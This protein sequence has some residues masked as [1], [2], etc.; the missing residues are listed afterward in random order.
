MISQGITYTFKSDILQSGE[1]YM[2]ALYK[3]TAKLGPDV[4]EAYTPEGECKGKGYY[5]GGQALTGAKVTVL[6]GVA[7]LDFD[8]PVW[9]NISV[10]AR[11]ALIYR[12]SNLRSVC[13]LDFGRD[14]VCKSGKFTYE[15]PKPEITTALIRLV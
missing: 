8:D 14:Q 9:E 11:G 4:T 7:I 6:S 12:K 3:D 1:T 13:V 15:M 10:T 2:I 5:A